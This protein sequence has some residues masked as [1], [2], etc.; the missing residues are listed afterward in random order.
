MDEPTTNPQDTEQ[1]DDLP[2]ESSE[3]PASDQPA[4][5]SAIEAATGDQPA[6]EPAAGEP[7]GE[8]ETLVAAPPA[9]PESAQAASPLAPVLYFVKLAGRAML[10]DEQAYA[11]VR[12][13]ESP[14]LSGLLVLVG[15]LAVV[16]VAAAIGQVWAFLLTPSPADMWQVF[17]DAMSAIPGFEDILTSPEFAD[18]ARQMEMGSQQNIWGAMMGG[19]GSGV[20]TFV[21]GMISWGVYGLLTQL[22]ARL[23]GGQGNWGTFMGVFALSYAPNV[24]LVSAALPSMY[25]Q[26]NWLSWWLLATGYLAVKS[27]H[28]LSWGRCLLAVIIPR[29][30]I[31][32]LVFV[33]V[34]GLWA[35]WMALIMAFVGGM[36][37]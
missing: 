11:E 31:A 19:L 1:D 34:F 8:L 37:P 25:Q 5:E 24:L 28:D 36:Q 14:I 3:E 18:M 2:G 27:T 29:I 21:F 6:P 30:L 9:A 13:A 23:L 15:V 20:I 26:A 32:L 35:V 33:L 17:V 7:P 4:P 10:F 16:G 12:D 22:T